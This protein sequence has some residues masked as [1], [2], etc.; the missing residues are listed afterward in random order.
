MAKCIFCSSEIDDQAHQCPV[1]GRQ[2]NTGGNSAATVYCD[3]YGATE[4][5]TVLAVV[6]SFAAAILLGVPMMTIFGNDPERM[7]DG[8]KVIVVIV[9]IIIITIVVVDRQK[10]N[11]TI[12]RPGFETAEGEVVDYNLITDSRKQSQYCAIIEFSAMSG[13]KYRHI[14]TKRLVPIDAADGKKVARVVLLGDEEATME[15]KIGLKVPISYN[16]SDPFESYVKKEQPIAPIIIT[17]IIGLSL[18]AA[19]MFFMN[20]AT[21]HF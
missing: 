5:K 6:L 2:I 21:F 17:A 18:L 11:R 19:G 20:I 15:P 4:S 12:N 8:F 14:D 16:P 10:Y 9:A 1:C 7:L 13:R 3:N